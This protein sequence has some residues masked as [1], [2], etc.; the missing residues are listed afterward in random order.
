M[1]NIENRIAIV[2]GASRGIG[3]AIAGRL[4][5]EGYAVVVNYASNA[6]AAED[7]STEL[8]APAERRLRHRPMSAMQR[9]SAACSTRRK[10]RSAAWTCW[11][12]T[13]AL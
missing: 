1:A 10:P 6:K 5:R 8:R 2:T 11:S 12:T 7:W 13:L 3:A 9:Q 4:A